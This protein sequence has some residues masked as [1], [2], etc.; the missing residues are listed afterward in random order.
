MAR[1]MAQAAGCGSAEVEGELLGLVPLTGDRPRQTPFGEA[2]GGPGL[3]TRQF[4]DLS[5][6]GPDR[7]VTPTPEVFVRTAPPPGIE[8]GAGSWALALEGGP[9]PRGLGID[10][11]RAAARPMGAHLIECA[12]NNDPN[13]FGLL[14]VA[15]WDGVR[16]EQVAEQLG[17]RGRSYGVQVTGVDDET[18]QARSSVAGAAWVLS[19]NDLA[20]RK[21]FL[22]VRM[23]GEP[24]PAAH[25][26]PV[27][28]AAPGWYGCSWI[29]W[30]REI[31]L[32]D[33]D[34]AA[35]TQMREFAGRTHQDG[36]PALARDYRAPAIDV[37]A[38]PVRVE[39]RRV[40]GRIAYRIVGIVWGGT[41]PVSN[42]L[43]RFGSRDEWKPL[44]V[45]PAPASPAAWSVWTYAWTPTEPGTYSISL[46]CADPSVRT[47]RLDMYFYTR[48]V[49]IDAV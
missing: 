49:R 42:L 19:W 35:T 39:Q 17:P 25:G 15:E 41:E 9:A 27:R 33:G 24:L 48:R 34:A 38:T 6:V 46:K 37:A 18:Q 5:L 28:L 47:R 2:V 44:R 13:N 43:I 23:N 32:V 30:V 45:C 8:T 4:T 3:D 11:L 1:V 22:A 14:S 26:A 16:L 21:P 31:R 12:G 7:L 40:N 36:V 10:E 29:K 20:A